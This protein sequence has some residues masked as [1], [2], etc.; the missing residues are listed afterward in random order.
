MHA[1]RKHLFG[2]VLIIMGIGVFIL[3]FR[4]SCRYW[5]YQKTPKNI[6]QKKRRFRRSHR[7]DSV[8]AL[9]VNLTILREQIQPKVVFKSTA[10]NENIN[11]LLTQPKKSKL[12]KEDMEIIFFEKNWH[13][14]RVA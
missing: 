8:S 12:K 2:D 3:V 11:L 6:S 4:F 5:I 7:Q 13:R 14:R 1:V 9:T 10:S